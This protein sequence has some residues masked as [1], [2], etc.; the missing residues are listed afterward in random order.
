M[1]FRI[2]KLHIRIPLSH[3]SKRICNQAEIYNQPFS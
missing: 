3:F 1:I 2:K